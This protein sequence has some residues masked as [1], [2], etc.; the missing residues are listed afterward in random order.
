MFDS[1]MRDFGRL[2]K[3]AV[4]LSTLG[5]GLS[6]DFRNNATVNRQDSLNIAVSMLSDAAAT[7]DKVIVDYGNSYVWPYVDA[8][9]NMANTDSA[10]LISDQSVPFK[11][12]VLHGFVHYSGSPINLSG[13]Y[14][15]AMLRSIEFGEMPFFSLTYS[16]GEVFM[17][18]FSMGQIYSIG[19]HDWYEPV[20]YVYETLNRVL[21][22]VQG[23]SMV[24]HVQIERNVA[25]TVFE[26]GV[27]ILVNY[28]ER[29]VT[30]G[31]VTV[32]AESYLVMQ[33]NPLN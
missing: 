17:Q 29:A 27:Y 6:S 25:M 20:I 5:E 32:E 18:A 21:G 28:N 19:F 24:D 12:A 26:N 9:L 10:N 3:E 2:N 11:Q 16:G 22:Q 30:V 8:I 4:S 15:R 23:Y 14:R 31:D 13:N 1:F 33:S 7:Y